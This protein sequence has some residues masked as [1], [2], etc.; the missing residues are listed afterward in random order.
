MATY[1]VDEDQFLTYPGSEAADLFDL[2]D[3]WYFNE[4]INLWGG[5]GNDVYLVG[6]MNSFMDYVWIFEA[7]G[8]GTDTIRLAG[9]T[10]EYFGFELPDNVENFVTLADGEGNGWDVYGNDLANNISIANEYGDYIDGGAG[11]DTMAA[12][13]G[14][15]LYE[16]DSSADVVVEG[17]GDDSGWDTVYSSASYVLPAN[18]EELFLLGSAN[19]N[20]TGNASD[21]YIEGNDGNNSLS[22]LGGDDVIYGGEG[23]NTLVGGDGDDNLYVGEGDGNNTMLGGA[24]NDYLEGADGNDSLD[25]GEGNDE[26]FGGEGVNVFNAGGGNDTIEAFDNNAITAGA[27]ND[28]IYVSLFGEGDNGNPLAPNLVDGGGAGDDLLVLYVDNELESYTMGAALESLTYTGEGMDVTG[29]AQSN[30]IMA[31]AEWY[32]DTLRGGA[33][34]DV[35]FGGEGDNLLIGGTGNDTYM[36]TPHYVGEGVSFDLNVITEGAAEGTADVVFTSIT[37]YVL[38]DN[39]EHL[40]Y[41]GNDYSGEGDGFTSFEGR[42]NSGNNSITGSPDNYNELYGMAGNDTL[43]PLDGWGVLAGGL[44]NDTY[45]VRDGD[46]TRVVELSGTGSGTDTVEVRDDYRMTLNVEVGR[47]TGSG[48]YSIWGNT[49]NNTIFGNSG[50]NWID[51]GKGN[52]SMAG[53]TGDD[54]YVADTTADVVTDTGGNDTVIAKTSYTLSAA[55]NVETLSLYAGSGNING[56]GNTGNNVI[57]GNAGMNTLVGGAGNDTLNG[58]LGK[59]SLQ[60]DAGND[61]LDGG[62]GADTM[63]GG[64]G[65]DTY[66]VN[67]LGD[68]VSEAGGGGIDLVVS[69]ASFTLSAGLDNLTLQG[70]AESGG[71]NTL[72]NSI[73]GTSGYNYLSGDAGNDTL[74]GGAGNDELDGGAGNDTYKVNSSGDLVYEAAGA[75]AG[76]ADTVL[77]TANSYT[78]S[79]NV[80][81]LTIVSGFGGEGNETANLIIGSSANNNLYG[82]GGNDTLRGGAGNDDLDGGAGNDSMDGG[83]G[84]D[85]YY[86]D[87]QLDTVTESLAGAAGGEDTVY[88]NE[89]TYTADKYTLGTN[90]E[91][92]YIQSATLTGGMDG[93]ALDNYLE[94]GSAD[95]TLRG[96]GGNDE[97]YGSGGADQLLGDVGNDELDGGGYDGAIDNLQGGTGNDIYDLYEELDT[98]TDTGGAA[99]VVYLYDWQSFTITSGIEEVHSYGHESGTAVIFGSNNADRI[100]LDNSNYDYEVYGGEGNDAITAVG[101]S[102]EFTMDGGAGADSFD[103]MVWGEGSS[104]VALDE[105]ENVVFSGEGSITIDETEADLTVT[106]YVADGFYVG[107]DFPFAGEG[108]DFPLTGE[109]YNVLQI[110]A[111]NTLGEDVTLTVRNGSQFWLNTNENVNTLT[112][113]SEFSGEGDNAIVLDDVNADAIKITG[114]ESL[115]VYTYGDTDIEVENYSGPNLFFGEGDQFSLDLEL[116]LDNANTELSL[117]GWWGADITVDSASEITLWADFGNGDVNLY[118]GADLTLT[119]GYLNVTLDAS[120]YEGNL[121]LLIE[122]SEGINVYAGEGA[123]DIHGSS[124]NESFYFGSNLYFD[125]HVDGAGG[126][127]DYLSA[128]ISGLSSA[129]NTYDIENVETIDFNLGATDGF[130]LNTAGIRG[131]DSWIYLQGGA[132]NAIMVSNLH[133]NLS[134]SEAGTGVVLE[135]TGDDQYIVT[136]TYNDTVLG[137]DGDSIIEG[138]EGDDSLDGGEGFDVVSYAGDLADI[139][140]YTGENSASGGNATGDT[141]SGFEGAEGGSGNDSLSGGNDD[142]LLIGNAGSDSL[143]G[144]DGDDT[145]SGGNG[146]DLVY[147]GEGNDV[148]DGGQDADY[149]E[150]DNGNDTVVGGAGEDE[151]YG[152][153]DSDRLSGGDGNDVLSGGGNDFEYDQFVFDESLGAGNVDTITDFDSYNAGYYDYIVLDASVFD[154]FNGLQ[155]DG[156]LQTQYFKSFSGEGVDSVG[157]GNDYIKYDSSTG[158]LYYDADGSVDGVASVKFATLTGA[159]GLNVSVNNFLLENSSYSET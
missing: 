33:G 16:V 67:Q 56:T 22:G 135:L 84:D 64:L 47:L 11:N 130:E 89:G 157:D 40:V 73:T 60:G 71:G 139:T 127:D 14:G 77:S 48:D 12:G 49:G 128:D 119:L 159:P 124:G 79:A 34:N 133:V 103:L 25:G 136:S 105:M 20:G 61:V 126:G 99:D 144:Y 154:V 1:I 121:T 87:G 111:G 9:S 85:D 19:L 26:L 98:F 91:N 30:V 158:D 2:T 17:A 18:V 92:G 114:D 51:G 117:E 55:S 75:P 27:G 69:A 104:T 76:T 123:D 43:N 65:N 15:D 28:V 83:A 101:S 100:F 59:D 131:D 152:G 122:D 24:G 141:I 6:D 46:D 93:N 80:E 112:I 108:D 107:E 68:V 110:N 35:L 54:T 13:D 23:N 70:A 21:N 52:D 36:V 7:A 106:S 134:A 50:D 143:Y 45:I 156:Q 140:I 102:S 147:A 37:D 142:N 78:L 96:L 129:D 151:V 63:T 74:D 32:D 153:N 146:N 86:V 42:G 81:N 31:D 3:E 57:I 41:T 138:G 132:G 62:T 155:S 88:V 109:G 120:E 82:V 113:N 125:D 115:D 149:I 137:G 72:A 5:A 150:A 8:A 118:G 58:G 97:L 44:G 53:G 4:Q 145:F 66:H 116:V 29:N 38:P 90:I 10:Y 94:G 39:V 148:V 95:D